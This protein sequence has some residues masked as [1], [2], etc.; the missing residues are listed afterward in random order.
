MSKILIVDDNK[1]N[2]V[3]I[4]F[5]INDW[6]EEKNI[7][8]LKITEAVDG[9]DAIEKFK[10][11]H[12][13]LVFMDIMMPKLSGIDATKEIRSITKK[14][15]MIIAVSALDDGDSKNKILKNG[16][17]DYITKPINEDIFKK[18]LTNYLTLIENRKHKKFNL[19]SI[20][21]INNQIYSRKLTFLIKDEATLSEFWDYYLLENSDY[22]DRI[23]DLIRVIYG[24]GVFQI[25]LKYNFEITVEESDKNLY[26]TMNNIK[27]LNKKVIEKIIL[28]NYPTGIYKTEEDYISFE[29]SKKEITEFK[30]NQNSQSIDIKKEKLQVFN[31]I[32][33]DDIEELES[34]ANEL[35]SMMMLIGN[36]KLDENEVIQIAHYIDSFAKILTTYTET[37]II[38]NAL[39]TL[40]SDILNNIENFQAK[41]KDI[42]MLAQAFNRDIL[43][44][45]E[46][47]FYEG[48]PSIDFLDSSII[49][50]SNMIS[51]FINPKS[52]E[53]NN[54]ELDN[55]FDF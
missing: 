53:F 10:K 45:I 6:C 48:A 49:S 1:T 34:L 33:Q 36:S 32:K 15:T 23:T 27:L 35:N 19:N 41:S 8:N 18:R 55:I 4:E 13:D 7:S 14:D 20:N 21:V 37:Y 24:L 16:A 22:Q 31:F 44:W 40:S 51:N 52:D 3:T 9:E 2:R 30:I 43:L 17:E 28:K 38:S 11:T 50:N 46:K 47:L 12:F 54:D 26:F 39:S 29:F 42:A 5:M 25:K